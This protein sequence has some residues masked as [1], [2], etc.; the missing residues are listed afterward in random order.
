MVISPD[1]SVYVP[2]RKCQG[3]VKCAH[4]GASALKIVHTL[5]HPSTSRFYCVISAV[6]APS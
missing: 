6:N 3:T 2:Q 4:P 5:D 1:C